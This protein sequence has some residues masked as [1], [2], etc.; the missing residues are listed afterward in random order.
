[1]LYQSATTSFTES[2]IQEIL[3]TI[4]RERL[5]IWN[6]TKNEVNKDILDKL[7]IAGEK[8]KMFDKKYGCDLDYK[9]G[10]T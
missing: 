7:N 1:M 2:E 4:E 3:E 6:R 10:K 8:L 9:K 5:D